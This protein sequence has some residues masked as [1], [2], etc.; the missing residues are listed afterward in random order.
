MTEQELFDYL[1]VHEHG[2]LATVTA[3]GAPHSAVVGVACSDTLELVFDTTIDTRKCLNLRRDGRIAF[4]F[5]DAHTT[6]QYEGIAD[7]PRG[8]ALARLRRLYWTRFP[9]GRERLSW[10]GLTYFRVR[11]L[12]VRYSDFRGPMPKISELRFAAPAA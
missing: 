10:P 12:W 9:D 2:V 4:T 1:Q 3:D 5:F 8:D 11:P 7:E 6:V